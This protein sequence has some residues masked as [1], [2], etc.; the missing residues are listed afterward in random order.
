MVSFGGFLNRREA[1]EQLARAVKRLELP[2]PVLVLGL[3]RGGIPVAYEV[4]RALRAPLEVLVVRKIGMPGAPELAIGAVAPL[5]VTVHQV[6][7]GGFEPDATRFAQLAEQER[8]ELLRRD[9]LYRRGRIPLDLRDKTVVVVDDG[10]ATGATMLAAVR[11]ARKGGAARVVVAAPVASEEA[12]SMIGAECDELV[13]LLVPA[14]LR[15]VGEWYEDFD[16]VEDSEVGRLLDASSRTSAP[17]PST[18]PS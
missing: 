10:I 3:P 12:V 9:Q 13:I 16:Q 5:G 8:G 6:S 2:P 17:R 15:A 14:L 18:A 1:G 7:G 11:A 4:A